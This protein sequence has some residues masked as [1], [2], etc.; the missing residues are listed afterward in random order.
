M[1][2]KFEISSSHQLKFLF[3]ILLFNTLRIDNEIIKGFLCKF[4]E[5]EIRIEEKSKT[6]V[7]V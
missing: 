6:N 1:K 7:Y 3:K 5:S 4:Y 2:H